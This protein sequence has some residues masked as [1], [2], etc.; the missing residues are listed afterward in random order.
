[1]ANEFEIYKNSAGKWSW[2]L[3]A[4]NGRKVATAGESFSSEAVARRAAQTAKDRA[5][6]STVPAKQV[7]ASGKP[8]SS[9]SKKVTPRKGSAAKSA[10]KRSPAT[11]RSTGTTAGRKRS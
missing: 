8:S 5:A 2:R 7:A 10:A 4:A 1:M 3:K 11:K 9:A 6:A